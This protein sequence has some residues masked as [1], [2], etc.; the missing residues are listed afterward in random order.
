MNVIAAS[1]SEA[2]PGAKYERLIARAKA[3]PA[4]SAIVVHPCDESS[5][6]GV[7]D[8]A[9]A[10]II[11]AILVGP[12]TKIEETAARYNLDISG[13]EIVDVPHSGAA[14]AILRSTPCQC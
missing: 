10:G 6:R 13:F 2:A 1:A 5:L 11:K 4:V 3:V 8:A 14:A 7:V 12:A 9:Q